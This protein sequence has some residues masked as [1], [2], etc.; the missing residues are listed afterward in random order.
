M[1]RLISVALAWFVILGV[2]FAQPAHATTFDLPLDGSISIIDN[3]ASSGP[4]AIEVQAVENFCLPVFISRTRKR[5]LASTNGSPAF[6]CSIKM[7][8]RFQNPL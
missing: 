8:R 4:V 1:R 6:R 2:S 5:P 3:A 7:G